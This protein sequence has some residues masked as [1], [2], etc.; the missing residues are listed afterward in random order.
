LVIGDTVHFY[1]VPKSPASVLDCGIGICHFYET[2]KFNNRSGEFAEL[3]DE[4]EAPENW[5]YLVS[6]KASKQA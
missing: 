2:E 4:P 6:Y 1:Y 5:I 3:A